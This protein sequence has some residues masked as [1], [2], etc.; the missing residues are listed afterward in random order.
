MSVSN[1]LLENKT[2]YSGE[3][4]IA[5]KR[6]IPHGKG[7]AIMPNGDI[8]AGHWTMGKPNGIGLCIKPKY[9]KYNGAFKDGKMCGYGRM[10]FENQEICYMEGVWENDALNGCSRI[11]YS[12]G[13]EYYGDMVNSLREGSGIFHHV[14]GSV[15]K[16][17]WSNDS[18]IET[19][20]ITKRDYGFKV[21][22]NDKSKCRIKFPDDSVYVGQYDDHFRPNGRGK[23]KY[24]DGS[25]YDGQWVNGVRQGTGFLLKSNGNYYHGEWFADQMHGIGI[26]SSIGI[27]AVKFRW[28]CNVWKE[29]ICTYHY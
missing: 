7:K 20:S 1:Y 6:K 11:I 9:S 29:I 28:E 15:I 8:Y 5:R 23:M 22:D 17:I 10:E 25:I 4:Y 27:Y 26:Y 3:V 13:T 18:Q 19:L 21:F 2:I 24:I 12:D 14:D 16:G